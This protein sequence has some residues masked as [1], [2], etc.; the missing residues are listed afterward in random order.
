MRMR[1]PSKFMVLGRNWPKNLSP[2]YDM[3][4]PFVSNH[5]LQLIDRTSYRSSTAY[6]SNK[7][8][9]SSEVK[10]VVAVENPNAIYK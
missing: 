10:W 7:V 9:I 1:I 6:V 8:F 2:K 4:I 3:M 5:S